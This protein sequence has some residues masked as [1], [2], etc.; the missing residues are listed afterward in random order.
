MNIKVTEQQVNALY[1][2]AAKIFRGAVVPW[3]FPTLIE[4]LAAAIDSIDNR[5]YADSNH[6]LLDT[7]IKPECEHTWVCADNEA[8]SGGE[9]CLNCLS[10]RP[11]EIKPEG[12]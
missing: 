2:A 6:L 4:D 8:V 7:V 11:A 3:P 10:I 5:Y 12:E 9:V 1:H